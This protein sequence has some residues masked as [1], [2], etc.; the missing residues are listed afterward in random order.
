MLNNTR[1]VIEKTKKDI[2]RA[3]TLFQFGTQII[4]ILYQ[5][6]IL[7]TDSKIWYLHLALFIISLAFLVFDI[8]ITR[9]IKRVKGTK[10]SIF[11]AREQRAELKELRTQ[12]SRVERVKNYISHIIKALVI[13][14]AIYAI[15]TAP[16][17]VHPLSVIGA[18]LM[19]VSWIVQALLEVAK[20]I[21]IARLDSFKEALAEDFEFVTR[22]IDKIK[23]IFGKED[24]EKEPDA[25]DEES[26]RLGKIASWLSDRISARSRK[27]SE[28]VDVEGDTVDDVSDPK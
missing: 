3:V 13:G 7:F 15:V 27:E 19:T 26:S 21:V 18:T 5:G 14:T 22:S 20:H 25:R 1:G 24:A 16:D 2:D 9:D 12:K 10:F 11:R 17:T 28:Y 6:I 8:V 23:K 4:F